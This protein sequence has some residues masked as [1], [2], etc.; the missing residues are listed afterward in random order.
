M[1]EVKECVSPYS[2][3]FPLNTLKLYFETQPE[4]ITVL[5]NWAA[6]EPRIVRVWIF[7][8]RATGFRRPKS[9]P[10]TEP[11]LDVAYELTQ[12]L[13]DETPYTAAFFRDETW[14]ATLQSQIS[15]ALDLQYSMID[16]SDANVPQW[17]AAHG[18][19]IYED[20]SKVR[21][22]S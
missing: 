9:E 22:W 21:S 2:C 14:K 8:S 3:A 13:S 7:G 17:V 1:V 20:L 12:V 11:D 10:V 5:R 18:V 19:L 15:V 6:A 4:W 16:Q